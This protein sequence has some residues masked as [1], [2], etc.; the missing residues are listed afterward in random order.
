VR[1]VENWQQEGLVPHLKVSNTIRFFWPDVVASLNDRFAVL[2]SGAVRARW[3]ARKENAE[4]LK[5]EILKADGGQM[6]RSE[7]RDQMSERNRHL[8]PSEAE[9]ESKRKGGPR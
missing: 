4:T 5:T 2:P 7:N 8:S 3:G 6:P 1:T 9:R